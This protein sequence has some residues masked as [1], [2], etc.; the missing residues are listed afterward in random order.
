VRE[1][2]S[3]SDL[4]DDVVVLASVQALGHMVGAGERRQEL[5]VHLDAAVRIGGFVDDDV[6][7]V[8]CGRVSVLDV[9]KPGDD[10]LAAAEHAVASAAPVV[11][12]RVREEELG[13]RV[14]STMIDQVSVTADELMDEDDVEGV[15]HRPTVPPTAL[16]REGR[17]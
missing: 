12:R 9:T 5:A 2:P 6:G 11:D 16:R 14:P 15:E 13:E 8:M 3:L 1:P 4:D 17:S 10:R 7:D